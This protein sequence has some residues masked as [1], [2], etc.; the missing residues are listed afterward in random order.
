MAKDKIGP[1]VS[2]EAIIND[3]IDAC[4]A[5][6]A[7]KI[8]HEFQE[9]E[10]RQ[11]EIKKEIEEIKQHI[12]NLA[13][14]IKTNDDRI[15]RD[16]GDIERIES[17]IQE[18]QEILDKNESLLRYIL[19]TSWT[20]NP[21]VKK[22]RSALLELNSKKERCTLA[23]QNHLQANV[24]NDCNLQRYRY[25]LENHESAL[26][27]LEWTQSR[28]LFEKI[29][30]CTTANFLTPPRIVQDVAPPLPYDIDTKPKA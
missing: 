5:I 29:T 2:N 25:K 16:T 23:I 9:Q 19:P 28:Q 12:Q 15:T 22:A 24:E 8:T 14:A 4:I 30:T 3:A 18:N 21:E 27:T 10:V 20:D 6:Y 26:R 11:S 7:A 13:T 1:L 17:R